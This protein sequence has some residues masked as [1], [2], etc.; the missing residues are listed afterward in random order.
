MNA[1][2]SAIYES[3][4]GPL[5]ISG[6]ADGIFSLEFLNENPTTQ[7]EIHPCLMDCYNQLDEYFQGKLQEF[8]LELR[9]EGTEFQIKV[10]Q[11]LL[12]I[13][14][15]QTSTYLEIAKAIGS[16]KA[17]R[18]VGVANGK[19]KI[20]IIIPCHRVIGSDGSLIGFGG[21]IWR[22]EFLLK[23]EKISPI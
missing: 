17:V 3:E 13:P 12:K 15:G 22:K 23:H 4:I 11:A 7:K 8:N 5:R 10:W 14:Y 18:A 20:P 21:G 6:N 1:I 9:P 2:H 16:K 19:N